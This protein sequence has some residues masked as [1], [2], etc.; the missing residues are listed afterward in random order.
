MIVSRLPGSN[1]LLEIPIQPIYTGSE[2]LTSLIFSSWESGPAVDYG[3]PA[4]GPRKLYAE[5][6]QQTLAAGLVNALEDL[7]LC[8]SAQ[9][10]PTLMF[11]DRSGKYA[12]LLGRKFI[13]LLNKHSEVISV[14]PPSAFRALSDETSELHASLKGEIARSEHLAEAQGFSFFTTTGYL[15]IPRFLFLVD[16]SEAEGIVY[17]WNGQRFAKCVDEQI[18]RSILDENE[19]DNRLLARRVP[20]AAVTRVWPKAIEKLGLDLG[21]DTDEERDESI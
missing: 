15:G 13:S 14:L 12:D 11:G 4:F 8:S 9:G 17:F 3:V 2:P 20:A 18:V 7:L 21:S 5:P 6:D 16:S 19:V 10:L 1:W